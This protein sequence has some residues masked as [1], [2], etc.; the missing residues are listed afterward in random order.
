MKG[1]LKVTGTIDLSQLWPKGESDADTATVVANADGF[2]FSA[3]GSEKGLRRTRVFEG[4]QI[5]SK[6]VIHSGRK[7]TVR[8]QGIDAP[9]LHFPPGVK[10]KGLKGN[11]GFFRQLQGETSTA[12]L[13]AFLAK[14]LP[15][16]VACE[17]VTRIDKPNDAFDMFGRLIGDIVIDS[18]SKK[19]NINQWLA[20]NG[21]ALPAYYNSMNPDEIRALQKLCKEAQKKGRGIWPHLNSVIDKPDLLRF[22]KGGSFTKQEEKADQGPFVI[23][24]LFRRRVRYSVLELNK[25]GP[26]TFKD[27]LAG[28]PFKGEKKG[29]KDAW[30]TVAAHKKDPT[31]K[32]PNDSLADLLGPGNKFQAAPGDIVFFE[33][34][35]TL[36]ANGKNVTK[37]TFV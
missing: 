12:R 20:Q 32:A 24:K 26:A 31:M 28:K 15:K 4:A 10:R 19:I 34:P 11:G 27:Y 1:L 13:A 18:G 37:W 17:V 9:E 16:V 6:D 8:L 14:G 36:K 3:D 29:T 33:A 35:S 2:A 25:L 21:W 23:P 5:G 7:V 30:T 22:R